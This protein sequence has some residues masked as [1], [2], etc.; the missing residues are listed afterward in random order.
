MRK[1]NRD[2]EKVVLCA[3]AVMNVEIDDGDTLDT[4]G[5]AGMF[6]GDGHVV[7]QAEA[8]GLRRFRVMSRWANC[9]KCV[10]R[11][12]IENRVDRRA[13]AANSAQGGL[14]RR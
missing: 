3:I 7:E 14:S 12:A 2:S 4:V 6:G 13:D 11:A 1:T 5:V 10:A 8:H 9:A